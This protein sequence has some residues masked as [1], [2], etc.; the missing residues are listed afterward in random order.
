VSG[1]ADTRAWVHDII[2]ASTDLPVLQWL[3]GSADELPCFVIG[4]PDLDEASSSRALL[5]VSVPVYALGRTLRDDEAQR[6]LDAMIDTLT[7]LLWKPPQRPGES[8][9]MTRA[10]ATVVTVAANEIPA[11]TA[12][13]I[14]AAQPCTEA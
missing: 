2:D 10:R 13:V 1:V 14:A 12:T 5:S 6:E 4:R 8:L 11:Y 3:P 9:R 7:A